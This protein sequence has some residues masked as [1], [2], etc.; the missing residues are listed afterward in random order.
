MLQF[1]RV[2]QSVNGGLPEVQGVPPEPM[3]GGGLAAGISG[4]QLDPPQTQGGIRGC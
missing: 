3:E 2:E 4:G 1:G